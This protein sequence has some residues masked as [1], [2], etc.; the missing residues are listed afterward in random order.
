MR[1]LLLCVFSYLGVTVIF[2][3]RDKFNFIIPYVEFR[4][5]EKGQLPLIIDSNIIIDGRIA[6][7]CETG[8]I[9]APLIMPRFV[10]EEV[11]YIA[12]S[13]DKIKRARGRRG[14]EILR[15]LQS[16]NKIE[17]EIK[18]DI[19]PTIKEVDAK[20]IKLAKSLHG[21]LLTNDFNLSQVAKLQGIIVVNMNELASAMKS[22][23]LPGE[24]L[25]LKLIRRGE[26]INQAIGYLD[27]GTM[28]VAEDGKSYIGEKVTLIISSVL[29]TN[30]GKMIFG[31]V[32]GVEGKG[33]YEENGKA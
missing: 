18:D 10:L 8:L 17:V 24:R 1:I 26:D 29:Q 23:V 21:R 25:V 31:R 5:E 16:N 22:V 6:D 7:V 9:D 32:A 30:I 19:A 3:T 15:R 20:L 33:S 12:D 14:L 28:V 13:K 11:Q 4:K 27:D 2:K